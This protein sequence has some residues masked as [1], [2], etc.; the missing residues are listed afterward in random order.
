MNGYKTK[1][2]KKR[3]NPKISLV[4]IEVLT[5]EVKTFSQCLSIRYLK[6]FVREEIGK[7]KLNDRLHTKFMLNLFR[8][9]LI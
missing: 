3:R 7:R 2:E 5:M 8:H 4:S 9:H 6:G 1:V